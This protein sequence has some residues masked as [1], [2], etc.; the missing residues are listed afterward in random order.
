MKLCT[1][2]TVPPVTLPG[3]AGIAGAFPPLAGHAPLLAQTDRSY[4]IAALLYG[5][6]G[7]IAVLDQSY[8]GIMPAW[9]QL[10]DDELAAVL[11]HVMIAWGNDAQL[12]S[13][14]APY[15]PDE[16]AAARGRDLAPLDVHELRLGLGLE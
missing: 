13:D 16:V 6:Q 1:R 7:P 12:P 9:A 14:F 10:S 15:Q 3:G 8:N 2:P 5:L 4:P 11:N